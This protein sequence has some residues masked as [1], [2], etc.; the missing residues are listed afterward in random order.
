MCSSKQ[1]PPV[2]NYYNIA[3]DQPFLPTLAKGILA[4]WGGN[5][6]E[7]AQIE[8]LL[9]TRRSCRAFADILLT[10]SGTPAMLLPRIQAIGDIP[11]DALALDLPEAATLPPAMLKSRR[12]LLL[13]Q[14]IRDWF[15]G[16]PVS[17]SH[18]LQ[19]AY[20]LADLLDELERHHVA[21]DAIA[22]LIPQDLAHH[23]EQFLAFIALAMQEYYP[24]LTEEMRRNQ[25][26]QMKAEA[27]AANPPGHPV[28][29][30]GSMGS[31]PATATLLKAISALP[32][33]MVILPGID[34]AT[35]TPPPWHPQFYLHALSRFLEVAPADFKPWLPNANSERQSF[36]REW[37][38]ADFA[39]RGKKPR[40]F[41]TLLEAGTEQDEAQVVAL[42]MRETLLSPD[43]TAMLVTPDRALARRVSA[44]LMRYDITVDDSAGTP[45][46]H[47]PLGSLLMLALAAAQAPESPAALLALLKHPLCIFG[48]SGEISRNEARALE[49]QYFRRQRKA[50]SDFYAQLLAALTPLHRL[51]LTPNATLSG[52][53]AAHRSLFTA[54]A[55]EP[56][57]P[58][59]GTLEEALRELAQSGDSIILA[60]ADYPALFA[61]LLT[62]FTYRP[63]YGTHPRLSIL[64]PME[65]RLIHADRVI[66][67]SLNDS[68]W[69]SAKNEDWLGD[70][71]RK[72]LK[73]PT[74]DHRRGHAAHDFIGLMGAAEIF[75]T[76]TEYQ[77][78]SP[79]NP[80]PWLL[81]FMHLAADKASHWLHWV[82]QL[83][84]TQ[85]RESLQPPMPA[86]PLSERPLTLSAT[87]IRDL[88][89]HPY[90][91][92]AKKILKLQPLEPY[93]QEINMRDIGNAIHR[94]LQYYTESPPR[95]KPLQALTLLLQKELRPLFGD[96]AEA[97]L[98][99]QRIPTLAAQFLV[100]DDEQ[101]QTHPHIFAEIQG[102][103]PLAVGNLALTLKAKADR[104]AVNDSGGAVII[105]YKT[106]RV[107]ENAAVARG[108]EPQ[109]MVENF[110]L[111]RQ[112]FPMG[113]ITPS[114]FNPLSPGYWKLS[115]HE[116]KSK[117]IIL[118]VPGAEVIEANL[119]KLL[120]AFYIA[121]HPYISIP[122]DYRDYFD[123]YRHLARMQEVFFGG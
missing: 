47:T 85:A 14:K 31:V 64:S 65:A 10:E 13:A 98:W 110:I 76:R 30:A 82:A 6:L 88:M 115:G 37:M 91:H 94:A 122:M 9:P 100:W 102:E 33:G 68:H 105:D 36:C 51:L 12:I 70:A 44:A 50:D 53:I 119:Q 7:L 24:A 56:A 111:Y 21:A 8:V 20:T 45:L 42:L 54:L 112:G 29:A 86:P 15:E 58:E 77:E 69:P 48:G 84:T 114:S 123:S 90:Q 104:I 19:W 109:L 66:I 92:Y 78:G 18:A 73:L 22:P 71:L 101:R 59:T 67:G 46:S 1:K 93:T 103:A 49:V 72:Q 57:R 83:Q 27:L 117:N 108:E 89:Q 11:E 113:G 5:P 40:D 16:E 34:G 120:E 52:C 118:K 106:G 28:I 107:P 2:I 74:I 23:R 87:D 62:D 4:R 25:L 80:H 3:I 55:G 26:L 32:Q 43:K 97:R 99:K 39:P 63:P 95:E 116:E 60:G 61:R 81:R 96:S 38:Q 17:L 75:L 79:Q 35:D 121:E 41:L